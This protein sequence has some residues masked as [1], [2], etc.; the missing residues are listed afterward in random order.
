VTSPH[1]AVDL[2]EVRLLPGERDTLVDRMRAYDVPGLSL[3]VI[4]DGRIALQRAYGAREAGR[5]APVEPTTLFQ[6][7]SIS[8]PVT[9]LA[10]LRLV[11]SGALDL[12]ADVNERL[13]AWRVPPNA[14]W[15]PR[16]TLRMLLSHSAGLTT[17]GFPGYRR[18]RP[19]PTLVEILTG[20]APANTGA[21]RVDLVPGTQFRY[22]GGGTVVVQLLLEELT[23]TPLP[24]LLEELVLGPLGMGDSTF[25]QPLTAS[26]HDRAATAH[27]TD[28]TPVPGGWHVYPEQAAAGLWTTP[29][30]LCRYAIAVQE[31]VAGRDAILR[32]ATAREMLTPQVASTE[33]IGGLRSVGLGPFLG[34]ETETMWFGHSGGNEGFKC[35]VL[36]HV[37]AGCG[38]AVMTNGD[39]GH[40]LVREVFA[41]LARQLGWPGYLPEPAGEPGETGAALD[42]FTGRFELR[43]GVE[44]AIARSG[45]EL[46]VTIGSQAPIPFVRVDATTLASMAVDALLRFPPD[47][48]DHV[49]LVQNGE[50]VPLRRR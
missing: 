28:G 35:H 26:L 9:A 33:R 20:T 1:A 12:D 47:G 29:A 3:A 5:P 50:E 48:D 22:S 27:R 17:S 7:C 2:L 16:V 39:A 6:A 30:D 31:A 38:A 13:T 32:P 49:L 36:A 43:P 23:G 15:Q 14:S 34:G 21:V 45:D 18:D 4:A 25:A 19:L 42:R 8:K 24:Q 37:E 41:A 46:P 11:D 10:L 44:V 40:G